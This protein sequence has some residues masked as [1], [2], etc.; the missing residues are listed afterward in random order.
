MSKILI[1]NASPRK[2]GTSAML[3]KRCQEYL[4]GEI[5]SLYSD[6]NNV[7]WILPK[8][9]AAEIIIISG[10]CYVDSYPAQV[11]YLLEELGENPQLCHGQKV[12]GI[13]N[14]G[15]PYVHTHE[16]GVRMLKLFCNDCNMQY[17]GGFVLGLGPLLDGKQ[18][19]EHIHAK[20]VVPAFNEF[21]RHIIKGEES[22]DTLYKNVEMKIP[23]LVARFMAYTMCKKIDK[24][25]RKNGFTYEQPSPYWD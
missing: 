6:I 4:D 11:V 10:S 13:I 20:K 14:G 5:V 2:S 25:L 3:A 24:K 1:I 8:I 17:Q 16:S 23:S 12:Y 22:P 7:D 15:M 18:L 21:L 19:E 9:D